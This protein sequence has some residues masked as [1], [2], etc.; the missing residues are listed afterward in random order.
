MAFLFESIPNL[1]GGFKAGADLSG[2]QYHVMT[3][4]DEDGEVETANATSDVPLGVLQNKPTA[5]LTADMCRVGDVTIVKA[6]GACT[7]GVRAMVDAGDAGKVLDA[8]GN[9][10]TVG[11]FL[12][13][14]V[15]GDL[16]PMIF[17][18]LPAGTAE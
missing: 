15:D 12:A 1:L 13:T 14:G 2:K 7:R 9:V 6:G 17:L 5:G 3:I 11:T 16:L 10:Q 8:T 18:P 4:A